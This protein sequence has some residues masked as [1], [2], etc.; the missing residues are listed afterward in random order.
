MTH[1]RTE[2]L[3]TKRV[4]DDADLYKRGGKKG[5]HERRVQ[6]EGIDAQMAGIPIKDNPYP[7]DLRQGSDWQRWRAGW[8]SSARD[9]VERDSYANYRKRYQKSQRE[10]YEAAAAVDARR[11]KAMAEQKRLYQK[12]RDRGF[13]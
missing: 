1:E 7:Q 12:A 11:G 8:F 6:Q 9:K 2:V 13:R 5:E 10:G 3:V 4:R